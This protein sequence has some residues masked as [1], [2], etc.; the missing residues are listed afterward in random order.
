MH[1]KTVGRV[2]RRWSAIGVLSVAA[3]QRDQRRDL[4]FV[5]MLL[6]VNATNAKRCGVV[7]P[8]W[9][10]HRARHRDRCRTPMAIPNGRSANHGA[11][12][13][14]FGVVC[15]SGRLRFN[16]DIDPIRVVAQVVTGVGFLGAGVIMKQGSSVRG[17]NTAATLW[18]TAA[19]G[20]LSGAWDWR[21]A[22]TGATIIIA[23]NGFLYPPAARMGRLHVQTGRAVIPVDYILEVVCQRNAEPVIRS[24]LIETV[25]APGFMLTSLARRDAD[26]PNEVVLNADV[27]AADWQDVRLESA[28]RTLSAAPVVSA[29]R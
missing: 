13:Y 19:V 10:S 5:V 7:G 2:V 27:A 12:Q 25:P 20:A 4:D 24:K 1:S 11:G 9:P 23:A 21:E 17:L 26:A 28:V 3:D 14:G 15:D 8:G 22:V 6:P 16:R 18:A 29:V